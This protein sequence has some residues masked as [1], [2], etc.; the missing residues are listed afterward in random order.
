MKRLLRPVL[1]LLA[2][3][4]P[5]SVGAQTGTIFPKSTLEIETADGKALTYDIEL[6][7]TQGQITQGLMHRQSMPLDAGML[8]IY[9]RPHIVRMWMHNTVIPL[10]MVFIGADGSI[11]DIAKNTVPF[12]EDIVAPATPAI[13]VLELNAGV[14][15]K[16]GL[17]VGDIV[18]HALL[19]TAK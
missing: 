15:D 13:A 9:A 12:S 3:A 1:I 17:K 2:L 18:R 19:G 16:D 8:F 6:A 14:A 4:L 11:V 10:D 5:L 7:L